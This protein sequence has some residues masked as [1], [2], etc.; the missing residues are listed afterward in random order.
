[1]KTEGDIIDLHH[2]KLDGAISEAEWEEIV[3]RLHTPEDATM[4]K[5]ELLELA[6][7]KP[8]NE[9]RSKTKQIYFQD[10]IQAV[11]N[12]QLKAHKLSLQNFQKLFRRFDL[13]SNGILSD[14]EFLKLV[15]SMNLGYSEAQIKCLLRK[16]D[17]HRHQEMTFSQC[18]VLFKASRSMQ[19]RDSPESALYKLS[20]TQLLI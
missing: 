14:T 3:S 9:P 10:F 4:L 6:Y 7:A 5:A 8:C 1:M 16:I 11:L 13:D 15:R 18:V 17:P 12:F 20:Q 19:D 2:E